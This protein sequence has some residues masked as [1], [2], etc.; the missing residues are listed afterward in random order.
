MFIPGSYH[1]YLAVNVFLGTPGYSFDDIPQF[2]WSIETEN[3]IIL[4]LE[5]VFNLQMENDFMWNF[6]HVLLSWHI[7]NTV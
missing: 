2:D 4:L 5:Y 7:E 1:V 6:C 3:M